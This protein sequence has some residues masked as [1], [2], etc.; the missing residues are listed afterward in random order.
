MIRAVATH[1]ALCG[2]PL[3]TRDEVLGVEDSWICDRHGAAL[4]GANVQGLRGVT[5]QYVNRIPEVGSELR[6]ASLTRLRL[7]THPVFGVLMDVDSDA[8][9]EVRP[10]GRQV[11]LIVLPAPL[12]SARDPEGFLTVDETNVG[13]IAGPYDTG[14][15]KCG[16]VELFAAVRGRERIERAGFAPTPRGTANT[17]V[18]LMQI[19]GR[20]VTFDAIGWTPYDNAQPSTDL[21]ITWS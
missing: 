6:G 16:L 2:L 9:L 18:V 17:D 1:C 21:G 8:I 3:P 13:K 4:V 15:P 20:V 19:G 10:D 14:P 7:V 5:T 12:V 11:V